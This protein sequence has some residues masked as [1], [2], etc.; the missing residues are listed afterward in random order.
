MTVK[1]ISHRG[2]SLDAP[3][4]TIPAFALSQERQTDGME[5]DV[6]MTSDGQVVCCH[7]PD[8]ERTTGIRRVIAEST[9]AELQELTAHNDMQGF[10]NTRIPLLSDTF[11]FVGPGREYYIEIYKTDTAIVPAVLELIKNSGQPQERFI[12]ISFGDEVIRRC[13]ELDP[14]QKAMLLAG[15]EKIDRLIER[16]QACHADGADLGAVP[17]MDIAYVHQVRAAGFGLAIWTVDDLPT[18]QRFAALGV[19]AITSNCAGKLKKYFNEHR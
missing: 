5:C 13:K 6:F 8:T 1:F 4:N 19:D 14:G 3:E 12:V 18:A 7:D 15:R 17:E 9:Y 16:L 11:K 2:E 10:E